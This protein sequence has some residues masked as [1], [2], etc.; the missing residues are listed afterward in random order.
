MKRYKDWSGSGLDLDKFLQIGD[1]V[2][3]EMQFYFIEVLPP[4]TMRADLIQIG[5]PN[6]HIKGLPTFSTLHREKGKWIYCGHCHLGQFQEPSKLPDFTITFERG[7]YVVTPNN[8]SAFCWMIAHTTPA[9]RPHPAKGV[10]LT[11]R[12]DPDA[13]T[14]FCTDAQLEKKT[15]NPTPG[16]ATDW[17]QIANDILTPEVDQ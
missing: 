2:D 14:V 13:I 17:L 7:E 15:C 8:S 10:N 12:L 4:A 9:Q 5:E 11:A 1:E 16:A 6:S 3:E